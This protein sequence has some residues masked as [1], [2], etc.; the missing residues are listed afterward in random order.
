MPKSGK[1]L[2][3]SPLMRMGPRA[4]LGA[5]VVLGCLVSGGCTTF[6]TVRSAEVS[7]GPRIDGA[8]AVSTPPGDAAAWFWSFDCAS[9]CDHV[10]FSPELSFSY[11]WD[12]ESSGSPFEVGAGFSGT[13][14]YLHG[15]YQ[16]RSGPHPFGVGARIGIPT[17]WRENSIFARYDVILGPQAR[18]LLTSSVFRHSGNSPNGMLPGTFTAFVQ[19]VG[20]EHQRFL[21][22][23]MAF[24]VGKVRRESYGE[25]ISGVSAFLVLGLNLT[26]WRRRAQSET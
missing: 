14:P 23:W 11:G 20:F 18:V 15:Y 21:T 4:G 13:H 7:P 25:R 3:N 1:L 22:P 5:W 24:V 26:L 10:I 9:D 8:L 19:G 16:L 12:P 17:G 2:S 6:A